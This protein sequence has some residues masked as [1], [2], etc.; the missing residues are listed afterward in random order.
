MKLSQ[1]MRAVAALEAVKGLVVVLAGCGLF[2]LLHHDLQRVAEE[3]VRHTHLNPAARL[4]RVFL[5]YAGHL[6]NTHLMQLALGAF[7]YA[8]VRLVEAY[9]LW[10]ERAWGELLAASSGAVY[11]PFELAELVRRPG[12]LSVVLLCLNLAIVAFMLYG[13]RRRRARAA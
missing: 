2:A 12:P 5:A 6:D 11:V 10:H 8:A 3:L 13:M 7:A 9:G 4:P 1:G